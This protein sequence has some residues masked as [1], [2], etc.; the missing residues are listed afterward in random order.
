MSLDKVLQSVVKSVPEAVASGYIDLESG[1]LLGIQTVDAHPS[2]VIDVL[3]AATSDLF[4]G[5]NVR[6]IENMFKKMR[7]L[8]GKNVN[9]FQEII[10]NSENLV[11]I[12]CRSKRHAAH[13]LCVVCRVSTNLGM[14]LT[15]TRQ[16]ILSCEK[17]F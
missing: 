6:M 11:H 3:A 12:F 10:V 1:M 4:Q 2:N 13:V 7:G 9:Y 17:A 15:K 14:A 16:A 5:S 8:E